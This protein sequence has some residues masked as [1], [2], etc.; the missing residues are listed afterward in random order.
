MRLTKND[1]WETTVCFITSQQSN[2][3]RI[4][5]NVQSLIDAYGTKTIDGST[6]FPTSAELNRATIKELRSLGLGYRAEYIKHAAE[7]CTNNINL[8]RLGRKEYGLLK[9]SL[10]EINGVGDKVADCIALMGYGRLEAFPIDVW[11]KRTMEKVYF[12]GKTQ[13]MADIHEF[14][15]DQ[16]NRHRGYAQQYISGTV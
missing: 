2:L 13:K 4:R 16:W 11:V 8:N 5:Q 12:K 1:P 3:K 15:S 6:R 14:A 10:M 9:D 7:Y